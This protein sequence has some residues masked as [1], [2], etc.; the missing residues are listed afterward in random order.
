MYTSHT[1]IYIIYYIY[2]CVLL[3]FSLRMCMTV[4]AKALLRSRRCVSLS[5]FEESQQANEMSLKDFDPV[6]G[7]GTFWLT[8][9]Q[10]LNRKKE[11]QS[12]KGNGLNSEMVCTSFLVLRVL[13]LIVGYYLAIKNFVV[14]PCCDAAV[15][16]RLP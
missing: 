1:H 7:P 9:V 12:S 3:L 2:I 11:W 14:L 8:K 5:L 15:S 10:R 13:H 4:N 6:L 16:S